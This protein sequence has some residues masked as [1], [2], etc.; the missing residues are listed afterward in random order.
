MDQDTLLHH[1]Q[2]NDN[3][4][5]LILDATYKEKKLVIVESPYRGVDDEQTERNLKYARRCMR[6]C[7]YRGEAP[8]LSHALY[9][10]P[11]VLDDKNPVERL[12]G[13]DAGL[14]WL[15]VSDYHVV[16]TDLGITQGMEY[17]IAAAVAAG[18]RIEYRKLD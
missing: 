15:K 17:G 16:Y 3:R 10:Q 13:I 8:F 4:I 2:L 18:K 14:A 7:L 12:A 11:G 5:T 6:D 1:K 9:T